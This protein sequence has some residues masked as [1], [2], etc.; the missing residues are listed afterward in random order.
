LELQLKKLHRR[1]RLEKLHRRLLLQYLSAPAATVRRSAGGDP[2]LGG[3]RMHPGSHPA[4]CLEQEPTVLFATAN[5]PKTVAL[6]NTMGA[7]L[8]VHLLH[9][10]LHARREQRARRVVLVL[11][12]RRRSEQ[13]RGQEHLLAA[14]AL[15]RGREEDRKVV[16]ERLLL[17]LLLLQ[18]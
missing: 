18:R 6:W 15:L 17:L 14:R 10:L 5:G 1:L 16:D 9:V 13:L 2:R 7:W 8:R 4:R 11:L 3:A 12:L